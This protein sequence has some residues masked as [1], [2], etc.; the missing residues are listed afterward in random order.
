ME[1][2]N[3]WNDAE[4]SIADAHRTAGEIDSYRFKDV[5]ELAHTIVYCTEA[6]VAAIKGF[7]K[8]NQNDHGR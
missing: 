7:A 2:W 3:E 8:V 1:D 4:Q 6:L 5:R